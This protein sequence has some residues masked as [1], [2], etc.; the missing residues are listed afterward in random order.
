[1]VREK[2]FAWSLHGNMLYL[3]I[4]EHIYEFDFK[5]PLSR[6]GKDLVNAVMDGVPTVVD[7]VAEAES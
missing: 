3:A 6:A 7:A 4:Q 5:I 1:V 2:Q